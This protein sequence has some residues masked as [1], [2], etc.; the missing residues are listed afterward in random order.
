MDSLGTIP[1]NWLCLQNS[2]C[3]LN[4]MPLVISGGWKF[5]GSNLVISSLGIADENID[6]LLWGPLVYEFS[7][8][9]LILEMRG[10]LDFK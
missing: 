9:C 8:L 4:L 7:G 10:L 1:C 6:N 5:S 3:I 2:L